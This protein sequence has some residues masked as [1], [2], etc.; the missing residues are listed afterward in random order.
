VL[1]SYP[2][3]NYSNPT[4]PASNYA[5]QTPDQYPR[6]EETYRI[7]LHPINSLSGFFRFIHNADQI[8][9]YYGGYTLGTSVATSPF[10]VTDPAN[11][12]AIGLTKVFNAST[13]N[14][15]VAG[16]NAG[17]ITVDPTTD[18]LTRAANNLS[19]LP[20][21]YPSAVTANLIPDFNF[22]G[23]GSVIS[24]G[25]SLTGTNNEIYRVGTTNIDVADNFTKILGRH[26]LKIGFL[27]ER[28]RKAESILGSV[29]GSYDFGDNS[30]NPFDTQLGFSNAATGTFASFTQK[31]SWF[32]P[33]FRYSETDFYIQ[34]TW[35]V[36][37]RLTA[38]LGMR[39]MHWTPYHDISNRS[40]SFDTGAF[41]PARAPRIY[42]Q[43]LVNGQRVAQ[44]RDT[45]A[46]AS[47][48]SIGKLV[49]NTGS[50]TNGLVTQSQLGSSLTEIKPL[51]YSPRVGFTY[52]LTGHGSSVLRAGAGIYYDRYSLVAIRNLIQNAP[53]IYQPTLYNGTFDSIGSGTAL[54][55]PGSAAS[56]DPRGLWPTSYEFNLG[57]QQELPAKF[58]ADISYVGSRSSHLL[59]SFNPAYIPYGAAFQAANQDP[60]KVAQNSSAK[61]G[62]NAYDQVYLSP[63]RGYNS[64]QQYQ[65]GASSNYNALQVQL[66]RRYVGGLFCHCGVYLGKIAGDYD[67]RVRW[68]RCAG[69]S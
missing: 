63:Y 41:D 20:V 17:K 4:N 25:S 52:D 45:G 9:T 49:P 64:I 57:V 39:F 2:T 55:S 1:Q 46:I 50:T 21:L 43:A 42:Y 60:V 36:S 18:R 13:V 16:Y 65:F 51:L 30:T 69:S 22:N 62:S 7:D 40:S 37:P 3:P 66:N 26:T 27:F 5:S 44:D 6:R 58:L 11:G 35:K 48:T 59:Q 53:T 38:I 34:D 28:S 24:T 33:Q 15:I 61:L 54:L 23:T 67:G 8:L 19:D 68:R 14:E 32:V 56:L 29:G 31:S 10:L 47:A 12:P